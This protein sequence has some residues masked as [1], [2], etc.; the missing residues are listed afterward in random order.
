MGDSPTSPPI[1]ASKKMKKKK[2]NVKKGG[3]GGTLKSTPLPSTCRSQL[4][5]AM[6]TSRTTRTRKKALASNGAGGA[7][8][9]NG[10]SHQ[11]EHTPTFLVRPSCSSFHRKRAWVFCAESDDSS[12]PPPSGGRQRLWNERARETP[13]R[14]CLLH[15]P[16]CS[17]R[18]EQ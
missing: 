8:V 2:S 11:G 18:W 5:P 1:A 13:R 17:E 3:G 14:P 15:L 9:V 6:P 16:N 10:V 12:M 7:E 4:V